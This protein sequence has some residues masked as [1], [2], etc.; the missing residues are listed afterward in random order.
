MK[1]LSRSEFLTMTM[2]I[3]SLAVV[4]PRNTLAAGNCETKITSLIYS[5]VGHS[6]EIPPADVADG[7]EKEYSI[8]GTSTHPHYVIV[9]AA[10]FTKLQQGTAVTITAFDKPPATGHK[11]DVTISC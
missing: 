6:L 7:V 1:K 11:H 8:Q 5:S 3:A 9:T 4:G 10:D 2:S